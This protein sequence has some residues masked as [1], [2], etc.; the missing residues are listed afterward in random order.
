MDG[1]S[2]AV[3]SITT[4]CVLKAVKGKK[5]V[6]V[7]LLCYGGPGGSTQMQTHNTNTGG[8][9]HRPQARS[10]EPL[11]FILGRPYFKVHTLLPLAKPK[12]IMGYLVLITHD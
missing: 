5:I 7:S 3:A 4:L 9:V 1:K 11:E 8:L 12:C 10:R 6:L 2:K